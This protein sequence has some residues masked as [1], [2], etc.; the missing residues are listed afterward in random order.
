MD[1]SL[2]DDKNLI[3]NT[4]DISSPKTKQSNEKDWYK[5]K[6]PS[7]VALNQLKTDA[8]G[9]YHHHFVDPM[10]IKR[11]AAEVP[12]VV[13]T[14]DWITEKEEQHQTRI[15][16]NTEG[17]RDRMFHGRWSALEETMTGPTNA[18]MHTEDYARHRPE[19]AHF[20]W[21]GRGSSRFESQS[22]KL[23]D[24]KMSQ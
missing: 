1:A 10:L 24:F 7:P 21:R 8:G 14:N 17:L 22:S 6:L 3:Q 15:I 12:D 16:K 13:S 5:Q 20:A 2:L 11:D 4:L 19:D 23:R 9:F 18:A